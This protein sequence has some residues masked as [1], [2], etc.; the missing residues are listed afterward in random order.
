MDCH[1]HLNAL[2][3]QFEDEI[4]HGFFGMRGDH[5]E[6]GHNDHAAGRFQPAGGFGNRGGTGNGGAKTFHLL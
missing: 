1:I 3:T 2:A 6:A 5:P 4:A